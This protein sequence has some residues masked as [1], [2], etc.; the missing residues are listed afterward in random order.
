MEG[1]YKWKALCNEAPYSNELNSALNRIQILD[2][3]FWSWEWQPLGKL[4]T[5]LQFDE[6]IHCPLTESLDI[7]YYTNGQ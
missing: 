6:G 5:S 4:H 2:L 1:W 3:T 7:V